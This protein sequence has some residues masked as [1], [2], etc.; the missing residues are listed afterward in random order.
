MLEG[1]SRAHGS[2]L[3]RSGT[4][5]RGGRTG[6][7]TTRPTGAVD[8]CWRGQAG[9]A[10][11]ASTIRQRRDADREHPGPDVGAEHRTELRTPDLAALE[12]VREPVGQLLGCSCPAR[13]GLARCATVTSTGSDP[14]AC[15][16]SSSSR[17]SARAGGPHPLQRTR[18]G[19]RR[20]RAA[21]SRR[22]HHRR[23]RPRRRSGR[24]GG[25]T[26]ACRRRTASG[27]A[28]PVRARRLGRLG[29]RTARVHHV[30]GRQRGVPG[31]H[32]DLPA[33]HRVRRA[34][35]RRGR[36]AGPTRTSRSSPR[37]GAPRRSP[38]R[39]GAHTPRRPRA[40]PPAS[41]ATCSPGGT[42]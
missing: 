19:P 28:R 21:A 42:P 7:W 14:A 23:A 5:R 4:L 15:T 20:S 25:G 31:R 34:R 24:R 3:G 41:A 35:T 29:G 27:T 16:A 39:R 37:T 10:V 8:D 26:R 33:V 36:R 32:P 9:Q 12:V 6:L 13:S 22:A 18:P 17:A 40:A 30:G 38:W 1:S 11:A 2:N